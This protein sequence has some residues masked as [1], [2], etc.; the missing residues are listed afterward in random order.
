M[1]KA[2]AEGDNDTT[3]KMGKN[4]PTSTYDITGA[5]PAGT[6]DLE[7]YGKT[8]KNTAFDFNT[9]Y[10]VYL[11]EDNSENYINPEAGTYASYGWDASGD[12]WT[13]KKVASITIP[14]NAT[15]ITLKYIGSG[16]SCYINGMRLVQHPAAAE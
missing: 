9:R 10:V 14:E 8:D 15:S 2:D 4:G 16:Y 6:Y 13:N 12:K 1:L 11:G 5:I 7:F 3:M